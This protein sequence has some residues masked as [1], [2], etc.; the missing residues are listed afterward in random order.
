MD[1]IAARLNA[2][3]ILETLQ[4]CRNYENFTLVWKLSESIGVKMKSWIAE[5]DLSFRD[6]RVPRRQPSTCLQALVGEK[7]NSSAAGLPSKPEDYH[8]VNTFFASLDKVVAEIENWFSGN[9][10]DVLCALGDITL[11]DS[12]ASESFDLVA[13]YYNLDKELLQADQR[14]FNRFKKA[15]V[16]KSIKT[17]AEV[18]DVLHENSLNEMTPEF[19]KVVSILAVIPATSC[20]AEWSFSGLRQLKTYLCNTMGQHRLNS[21]AII[22]IECM[23]GNQ[24]IVNS[25]DKM[26]NIF[27][28]RHGRKNLFF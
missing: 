23:Y 28:Q 4:S 3:L 11:S 18:I 15:H 13:S 10:Q 21:L 12:P 17:A 5:S 20:L 2:N 25:M 6:A 1:V 14:L 27:G 16:E 7:Q 8:Q 9:D 26:I 24:V 22:T 19:S